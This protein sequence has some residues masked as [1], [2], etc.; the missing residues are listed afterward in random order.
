MMKRLAVALMVC[1]APAWTQDAMSLRDAVNLAL[2]KNMSI[3]AAGAAQNA[4][5][6][7][8]TEARGGLLPKLNYSESWTRSDNPVFV[9]SSLLTQHQFGAMNFELGPLNRP[10]FL[11]NF[12]SQLTAEQTLYD[13]G[14]TRHAVRS[15]ELTRDAAGENRRQME[16]ETIASTVRGYYAALLSAE[17]L[18][19]A[20][21]ALRSAA[22]DLERAQA[23]RSAGM[24]TD[25]DVLSIRVH[26]AGI[27][28]QKIRRSADLEVALAALNEVLGLPLDAPHVLSTEMARLSL[29]DIPLTAYETAALEDR[30]E[31]RQ[32][33][34]GVH[35]AENQAAAAR[36]NLLPQITLHGAF[37]ADRQ[38]FYDRGADNWLVSLG[39]RW[40]LF[41]G[42]SDKARV[43]EGE[44]LLQRSQAE[45]ERTGS[46]I[47]L[48]VRRAWADLRASE[49]RIE[50]AKASVEEAEE[51]LRITRNR[52][53][54]GMS[55]VTDL[56]RT[57]AAAFD[58]RTRYLA[59]LH[60]QRIAATMLEMAA[61]R[62]SAVSEVLN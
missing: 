52:Y 31:A 49:Q 12:Q 21:Q 8:I 19:A 14:Q 58:A 46:T 15:A 23:I 1:G 11:S 34:I 44:S 20:N 30:A 41:N 55:N 57:E 40:N 5:E 38:R 22:A 42:F 37:E 32:A 26:L 43:R 28:E 35:L 6:S 29:P 60:D 62:L 7:R 39:L 51:S 3:A 10:G 33:K 27:E 18:K 36:G 4:A 56:L 47:H 13:A 53:G 17:Q 2:Q 24:S 61:G 25:V 9:F 50:G 16:M 48:Q 54:A 59:A 45:K